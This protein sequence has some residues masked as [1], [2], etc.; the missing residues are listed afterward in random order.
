[1]PLK[2][3]KH[4]RYLFAAETLFLEAD[5]FALLMGS[6]DYSKSYPGN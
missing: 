2:L 6:S 1:M 3:G 4:F 5:G